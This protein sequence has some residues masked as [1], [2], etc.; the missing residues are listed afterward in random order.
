MANNPF[1]APFTITATTGTDSFGN[2]T[3]QVTIGRSTYVDSGTTAKGALLNLA[4]DLLMEGCDP[5]CA[6]T[7]APNTIQDIIQVV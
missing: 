4:E 3:A 6:L 2:P 7:A 5:S 1:I